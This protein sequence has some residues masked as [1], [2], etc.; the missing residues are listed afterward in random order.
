MQTRPLRLITVGN[1]GGVTLIHEHLI[2]SKRMDPAGQAQPYWPTLWAY[3]EKHK[4]QQE[5]LGHGYLFDSFGLADAR[6][7]LEKRYETMQSLERQIEEIASREKKLRD[8][9]LK[10]QKEMEGLL[11]QSSD[12]SPMIFLSYAKEDVEVVKR[13][14][15]IFRDNRFRAWVYIENLVGGQEWEREIQRIINGA[16]FV[17][18]WYQINLQQI[19]DL[20]M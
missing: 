9:L 8:L 7:E 15:K 20:L 17:V 1:D 16:D 13:I 5:R 2:Q 6:K 19:K 18:F 10:K 3:I 4:K 11:L 14:S 12:M